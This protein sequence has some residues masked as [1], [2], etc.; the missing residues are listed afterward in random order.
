MFPPAQHAC[1]VKLHGQSNSSF[2]GMCIIPI[3]KQKRASQL[4]IQTGHNIATASGLKFSPLYTGEV[5]LTWSPASQRV[6]NE[7]AHV[8][9]Y[10]SEIHLNP[11]GLTNVVEWAVV[12]PHPSRK[13]CPKAFLTCFAFS[14]DCPQN[15]AWDYNEGSSTL[16]PCCWNSCSIKNG[17]HDL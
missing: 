12:L 5:M 8:A 9:N 16:Q 4:P 11:H 13:T 1:C 15:Q 10:G 6:S 3:S 7:I 2:P 17:I 14:K